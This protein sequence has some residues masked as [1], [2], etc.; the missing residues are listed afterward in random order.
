MSVVSRYAS[1]VSLRGHIKSQPIIISRT[2][3]QSLPRVAGREIRD[4]EQTFAVEL[5]ANVHNRTLVRTRVHVDVRCGARARREALRGKSSAAQSA[6]GILTHLI[7]SI[8]FRGTFSPSVLLPGNGGGIADPPSS[9]FNLGCD[10]V[11]ATLIL[12]SLLRVWTP[13]CTH[14]RTYMH[15]EVATYVVREYHAY[16]YVLILATSIIPRV[17][18]YIYIYIYIVTRTSSRWKLR[19]ALVNVHTDSHGHCVRLLLCAR[20]RA[21][22][23]H[24]EADTCNGPFGMGDW[25]SRGI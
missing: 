23:V 21:I 2:F 5:H 7:Q 14:V 25:P 19:S 22:H 24:Y 3:G 15:P 8:I 11:P 13:T 20:A 4:F 9:L 17:G 1:S 16:R 12:E 6:A 18:E 10:L